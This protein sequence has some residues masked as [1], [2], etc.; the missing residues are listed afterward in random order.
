M[1]AIVAESGRRE[2]S[3]WKST[4][5]SLDV[6][7]ERADRGRDGRTCVRETKFLVANGDTGKK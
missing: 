4:T 6:E 7:N 2:R 5:F 3:P 1:D